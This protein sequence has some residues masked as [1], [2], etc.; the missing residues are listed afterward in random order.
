MNRPDLII[1]NANIITLDKHNTIAGSVA[2][3]NGRISGI[4]KEQEPP[5]NEVMRDGKTEVLN[6]K[7]RTLL[8]GFIDTHNHLLMYAIFQQQVDCRTPPNQSIDDIIKNIKEKAETLSPGEWIIGWGYDDTLL[9]EKR[10][11][12]REDL[13]KAAPHH[14]VYI[15]HISGHLAAVNSMALKMA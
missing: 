5:R 15:S 4:W 3:T 12:T 9:K 8:P 7:G 11:P 13:D 14:P 1:T 10:H 2:V 6:L